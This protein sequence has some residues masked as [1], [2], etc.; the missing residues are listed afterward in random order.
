M[1]ISI[2]DLPFDTMTYKNTTEPDTESQFWK[3]TASCRQ[4]R[5]YRQHFHGQRSQLW[6]AAHHPRQHLWLCFVCAISIPVTATAAYRQGLRSGRGTGGS[7]FNK[8]GS[9]HLSQ[10]VDD[11]APPIQSLDDMDELP[12][13]SAGNTFSPPK[14]T[15]N[16]SSSLEQQQAPPNNNTAAAAADVPAVIIFGFARNNLSAVLDHLSLIGPIA[17]VETPSNPSA[18]WATITFQEAWQAARAVRRN[19]EAILNGALIIGVKWADPSRVDAQF[20]AAPPANTSAQFSLTSTRPNQSS[21]SKS[22]LGPLA[23]NPPQTPQQHQ[24]PPPTVGTPVPILG[25]A[26]KAQNAANTPNRWSLGGIIGSSAGPQGASPAAMSSAQSN[27][28]AVN[29]DAQANQQQSSGVWSK[30]SDVIFGF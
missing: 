20:S 27:P 17:S 30:V 7:L 6:L 18:N 4:H 5:R 29:N 15:R 25:S 24:Q 8:K 2:Q 28:F 23:Q 12:S 11:D 3:S 26:Y 14:L 13:A 10:P 19:G 21:S 1:C 22:P 16:L 9:Q